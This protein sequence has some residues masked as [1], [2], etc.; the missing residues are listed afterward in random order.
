MILFARPV[1]FATLTAEFLPLLAAVTAG[2][3]FEAMYNS[4][5]MSPTALARLCNSTDRGPRDLV[6]L[7]GHAEVNSIVGKF[8]RGEISATWADLNIRRFVWNARNRWHPRD[9]GGT[10]SLCPE[11]VRQLMGDVTGAGPTHR[12]V[13]IARVTDPPASSTDIG[14]SPSTA[15]LAPTQV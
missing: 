12:A 2:L 15:R 7:M 1:P 4:R 14:P 10:C 13:G 9:S 5:S 6:L 8:N 3:F 11:S